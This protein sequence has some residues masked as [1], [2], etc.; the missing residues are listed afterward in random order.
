MLNAGEN[1]DLVVF[2]E[3]NI[4]DVINLV[5]PMIDDSLNKDI[6]LVISILKRKIINEQLSY[7]G[8]KCFLNFLKFIIETLQYNDD[9]YE[10]VIKIKNEIDGI[11]N[12][13]RTLKIVKNYLRFAKKTK[14]YGE[15]INSFMIILMVPILKSNRMMRIKMETE[16]VWYHQKG[17]TY[18]PNYSELDTI[19]NHYRS[20]IDE[21]V[22][23]LEKLRIKQEIVKFI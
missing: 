13:I 7:Q 8:H 3:N 10:L 17:L 21:K 19:D 5:Q 23:S 15:L 2:V 11:E 18:I 12:E 20:F 9:L 1:D 22:N 14:K 16:V 6:N 4:Q